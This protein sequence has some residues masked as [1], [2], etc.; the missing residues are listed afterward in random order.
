MENKTHLIL[1]VCG[2]TAAYRTPDLAPQL[3]KVGI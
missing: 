2:S 3:K 1:G